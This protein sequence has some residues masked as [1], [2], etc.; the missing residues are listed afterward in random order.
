MFV[1]IRFAKFGAMKYIGHLD[2]MRYFQK[3]LR[4]SK[5]DVKYTEGYHP[6]Q[7]MSFAMPL[8]VGVTSD[9]EYMDI[10]MDSVPSKDELIDRL[11]AT[12]TS[13]FAIL[14]AAFLGERIEGVHH[15][16]SMALVTMADYYVSVRE[17]KET[18]WNGREDFEKKFEAFLAQPEITVNK[19]TKKS[20]K[21]MDIRPYIYKS[22]F[23]YETFVGCDKDGQ[24][25]E[26]GRQRMC[27]TAH[28]EP[29]PYGA[30]LR[31]C[32]GSVMNIKPGLV[33]EAFAKSLG[34]EYDPFV[35]HVHRMNMY[36]G[37]KEQPVSLLD[38][39]DED[40]VITG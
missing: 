4:R 7:I 40:R 16:N 10:E 9:G 11:G 20:E 35:F 29:D 31:L 6:H 19:K 15:E 34:A 1:R 24:D 30:Y 13:G 39:R 3:A 2:V 36:A 32:T 22:G 38:V 14:D 33:M 17:G 28:A 27:E 23:E 21:E 37:E 26:G 12:M 5:L 25:P 18:P 8:G